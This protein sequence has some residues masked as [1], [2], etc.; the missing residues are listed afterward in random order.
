MSVQNIVAIHQ[1]CIAIF[2]L[3]TEYSMAKNAN[4]VTAPKYQLLRNS[5]ERKKHFMLIGPGVV[6]FITF[7]ET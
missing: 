6:E 1:I 5:L 2:M 3:Q 7:I 4:N